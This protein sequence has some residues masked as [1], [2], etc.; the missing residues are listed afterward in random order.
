MFPPS[1]TTGYTITYLGKVSLEVLPRTGTVY[2]LAGP[3]L[4]VLG[5][6]LALLLL[7][8][9]VL[10]FLFLALASICVSRPFR[11]IWDGGV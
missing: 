1:R 7:W 2:P 6:I 9:F 10:F 5:F 3:V 11:L 4:Y 8:A